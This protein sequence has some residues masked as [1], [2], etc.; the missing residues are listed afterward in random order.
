M[1]KASFLAF[2]RCDSFNQMTQRAIANEVASFINMTSVGGD[3]MLGTFF[4]IAF[5]DRQQAVRDGAS[6]E[7]D[8]RW[9]AAALK[10]DWCGAKLGKAWYA[11]C[12]PG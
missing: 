2:N 5:E 1:R 10:V 8:P 12:C 3:A 9:A 11:P 4:A 7:H 6:S